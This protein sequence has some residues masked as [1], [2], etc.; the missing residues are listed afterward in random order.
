MFRAKYIEKRAFSTFFVNSKFDILKVTPNIIHILWWI[1]GLIWFIIFYGLTV[2]EHM[3]I[4][5]EV[6]QKKLDNR[7]FN[8]LLFHC[9]LCEK[10]C[11]SGFFPIFCQFEAWYSKSNSEKELHCVKD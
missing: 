9:F 1:K 8:D 3:R 2:V 4:L 5:H 7:T 10:N 11:K 6:F